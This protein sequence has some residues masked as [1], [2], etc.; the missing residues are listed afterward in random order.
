M[1]KIQLTRII[2]IVGSVLI[3]VGTLLTTWMLTTEE[4]RNNIEINLSDKTTEAIKFESLRLVPGEQCEYIITLKRDN[5]D[6][7][8]LMLD[9]VETEEKTLKNYVRVKI[10][11]NVETVCDELLADAFEKDNIVLPI[12]FDEKKNS[13][14]KIVYYLP[15]EVGNEAKNAEAVFELLVTASNE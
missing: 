5:A 7:Y 15:I 11:A 8:D 2:L 14:I 9:F 6:E 12:N 13:E 4:D 1:S 10:I 3:I